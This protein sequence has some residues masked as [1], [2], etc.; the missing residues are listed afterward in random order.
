MSFKCATNCANRPRFLK[1]KNFLFLTV[2]FELFRPF[3]SYF[4]FE[5]TWRK[6]LLLPPALSEALFCLKKATP[7]FELG[8][9]SFA[10]FCLTTWPCRLIPRFFM[11]NNKCSVV[12]PLLAKNRK[13]LSGELI[14][15]PKFLLMFLNFRL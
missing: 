2:I 9:K 3:L 11:I 10:G 6:T 12:N 1:A 7:R 5:K 14:T 8:D 13:Y 4:S 15:P